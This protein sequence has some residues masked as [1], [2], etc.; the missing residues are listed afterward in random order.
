MR[1]FNLLDQ[2][3]YYLN[4]AKET[5]KNIDRDE[6]KEDY[7][8]RDTCVELQSAI[9]YMIKG[10]IEHLCGTDYEHKHHFEKNINILISNKDNI[11]DYDKLKSILDKLS[12][13][14]MI[15]SNWH[16][17]AAYKNG[18]ATTIKQIDDAFDIG[19]GLKS[20]IKE[21]IFK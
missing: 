17:D 11:N 5:A 2:G 10:L 14:S 12:D 21:N 7:I 19:N 4:K 8:I 13:Y 9:E 16:T 15:I 6:M 20:Y 18:F 3:I 1:E